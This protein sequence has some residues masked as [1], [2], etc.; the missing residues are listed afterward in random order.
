MRYQWMQEV[1]DIVYRCELAIQNEDMAAAR[2]VDKSTEGKKER[3][4]DALE[5]K[6]VPTAD[7]VMDKLFMAHLRCPKQACECW[8]DVYVSL[9]AD[10]IAEGSLVP[11]STYLSTALGC[12]VSHNILQTDVDDGEDD[13]QNDLSDFR[14]ADTGGRVFLKFMNQRPSKSHLMSVESAAGRRVP[15]TAFAISLHRCTR[16][17]GSVEVWVE[18]APCRIGVLSLVLLL[19]GESLRAAGLLRWTARS[20]I[21]PR[22][23][24]SMDNNMCEL[25]QDLLRSGALPGCEASL[26]VA[27]HKATLNADLA[28]LHSDGLVVCHH[29]AGHGGASAWSLIQGGV[30]SLSFHLQVS[31][32]VAAAVV[33]PGRVIDLEAATTTS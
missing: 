10:W 19:P 13:D 32:P 17:S 26:F 14:A 11:V 2:K 22:F 15:D 23:R 27:S 31:K 3:Q 24:L 8:M 20:Q 6:G 16:P 12:P 1:R 18:V 5:P 4:Q 25:A 21:K 29:Q 28:L 33:D 7:K 30:K 9:H